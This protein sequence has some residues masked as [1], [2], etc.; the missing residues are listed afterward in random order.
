MTSFRLLSAS[1]FLFME[2]IC[3]AT[4]EGL[5]P[6]GSR[7]ESDFT[8]LLAPSV[9]DLSN[10]RSVGE[11][12]NSYPSRKNLS[13]SMVKN[14]TCMASDEKFKGFA[15]A[16]EAKTANRLLGDHRNI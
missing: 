13:F 3:T 2:L 6:S 1:A 10:F 4:F 7:A 12:F 15:I 8:S 16:I 9:I 11:S 5:T 14:L